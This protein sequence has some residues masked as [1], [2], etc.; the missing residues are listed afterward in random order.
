[1]NADEYEEKFSYKFILMFDNKKGE[2]FIEK[3]I[4][5]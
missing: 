5:S 3:F 4:L 1:M 2:R